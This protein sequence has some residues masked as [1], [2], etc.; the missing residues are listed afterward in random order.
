M[1]QVEKHLQSQLD[2]AHAQEI[3]ERIEDLSAASFSAASF[4]NCSLV[5]VTMVMEKHPGSMCVQRCR[6]RALLAQ[7]STRQA[8]C[9]SVSCNGLHVYCKLVAHREQACV[10]QCVPQ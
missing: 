1:Q 4:A 5:G 9:A 10:T 7:N 3:Q 8:H 2:K 6:A